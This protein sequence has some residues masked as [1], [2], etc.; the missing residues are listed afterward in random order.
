MLIEVVFLIRG[1]FSNIQLRSHLFSILRHSLIHIACVFHRWAILDKEFRRWFQ[2]IFS[3]SLRVCVFTPT[4]RLPHHLWLGSPVLGLWLFLCQVKVS[5]LH[6]MDWV[7]HMRELRFDK[8]ISRRWTVSLEAAKL[9]TLFVS[10]QTLVTL[11]V[12]CMLDE[13]TSWHCLHWFT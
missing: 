13:L 6:L 2:L 4:W 1:Y 7:N 5:L 12:I 9:A 11:S 3:K 8:S 10:L